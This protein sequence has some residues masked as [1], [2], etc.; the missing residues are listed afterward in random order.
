MTRMFYRY[1][2]V[3]GPRCLTEA[4]ESRPSVRRGIEGSAA[5]LTT[6]RRTIF[7]RRRVR[8]VLDGSEI[9]EIMSEVVLKPTFPE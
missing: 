8:S 5:S 6:M 2:I 7:D 1:N 9:L 4:P 3:H